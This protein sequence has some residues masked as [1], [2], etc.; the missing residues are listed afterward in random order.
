LTEA[1][2]GRFVKELAQYEGVTARLRSDFGIPAAELMV[3]HR[4]VE[5]E[6]E[7]PDDVES[8]ITAI[9]TN[10]YELSVVDQN[11]DA[12][13]IRLVET[14]TSTARNVSVP[15]ELLASPIYARVRLAY[16]KLSELIGLPPF[17]VKVGKELA[18]AQTFESLRGYVLDAAKQG[19]QL[20]RFKGLGEMN[21]EQLWE[22]TMDPAKR[23]LI[24]VDVDDAHAADRLFSMLMGDAVE[25]RRE[26]IEQNAKDVKF[27]DV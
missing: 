11:P 26:F 6:I 2:W 24:R 18:T 7:E 8:A 12:F 5:H 22:T 1:K 15:V 27:L 17:T 4:L 3:Q 10:G 23:L 20:S 21:A 19:L 25:P 16:T 9:G 14:E 13:R